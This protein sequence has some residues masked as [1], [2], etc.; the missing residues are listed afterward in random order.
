MISLFIDTADKT[1]TVGILKDLNLICYDTM[2]NKNNL[3]EN[4]LNIIKNLFDES[5]LNINCVEKIFVVNGPG[6]FT[7]IRIGVTVAK[8]IAWSLKKPIILISK[9]ETLASSNTKKKYIVPL[10]DA[11][12]GYIFTGLYNNK[13]CSIIEDEYV[14]YDDFMLNLNENYDL[15]DIEF[16][17]D[18]DFLNIIKPNIDIPKIVKKH[19][20]DK[21]VNPHQANPNYLKKTEAEENLIKND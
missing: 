10:I 20:N 21:G 6:S 15:D 8:V 12:R 7:G 16:V 18:Y 17:S 5:N 14:L 3:S 9:L 4:I 13:L 1:I 2:E 19:F 11:R